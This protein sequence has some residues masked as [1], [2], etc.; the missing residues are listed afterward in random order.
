[1]H[2]VFRRG[3]EREGEK[4]GEEEKR[5]KMERLVLTILDILLVREYQQ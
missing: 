5:K 3:R 1:M 4:V 2:S